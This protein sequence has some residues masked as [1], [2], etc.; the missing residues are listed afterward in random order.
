MTTTETVRIL[1]AIF[2]KRYVTA[3]LEARRHS[4]DPIDKVTHT[5]GVYVERGE[6][7]S[8][9]VP[10]WFY[11]DVNMERAFLLAMKYFFFGGKEEKGGVDE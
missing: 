9:D 3:Q 5:Y 6:E 8:D 2:P 10:A 11:S 7:E 1:A 4:T